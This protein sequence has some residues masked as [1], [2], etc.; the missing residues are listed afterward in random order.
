MTSLNIPDIVGSLVRR[1]D[2]IFVMKRGKTLNSFLVFKCRLRSTINT[3]FEFVN[4][5][6]YYST[7][8][9]VTAPTLLFNANHLDM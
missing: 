9:F 5:T 3:I 7:L 8:P 6:L 4:P 2:D 1:N